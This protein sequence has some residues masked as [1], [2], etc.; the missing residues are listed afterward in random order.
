MENADVDKIWNAVVT[1]ASNRSKGSFM[2]ALWYGNNSRVLGQNKGV[3][4]GVRNAPKKIVLG[5]LDFAGMA[6]GLSAIVGMAADTALSAGK[7][8]YSAQIKPLRKP[9]PMSAEEAVRKQVKTAVK[10]MKSNAF[11]VIDRNLVKLKDAARK[12]TPSIKDLMAAAP[13]MKYQAASPGSNMSA[14]MGV[15]PNAEKQA[16]KAHDA[17]RNIAETEYYIDKEMGLVKSLKGALEALEKDLNKMQEKT[18]KTRKEV[19]EYIAE[20]ID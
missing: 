11:Q 5:S 16:Q 20:A 9:K 14:G 10:E 1:E 17:L 7:D 19:M 13:D 18:Q 6:P 2:R 8:L 12:V 3:R 4:K 15:S